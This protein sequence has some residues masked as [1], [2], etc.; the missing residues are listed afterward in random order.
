[1]AVAAGLELNALNVDLVG[2]AESGL[3]YAVV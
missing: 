3:A 2:L 1:M